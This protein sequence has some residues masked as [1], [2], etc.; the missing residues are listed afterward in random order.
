MM[1]SSAQLATARTALFSPALRPDR[2]LKAQGSGA[3]C[4]VVDLEDAV[5][6]ADKDAA[7]EHLIALL[8]GTHEAGA[9]AGPVA[10]R[11]NG[12]QTEA[13]RADLEALR[14][15]ARAH[16]H[17]ASARAAA[18]AVGGSAPGCT[19]APELLDAVL[20]P[21]LESPDQ[22]RDVRDG[23]GFEVGIVGTVESAAGLLALE[24][25]VAEPGVVR[26]AVGALDLAFDLGCGADSRTMAAAMAR[27]VTVSRARGLAGPLDS[28]TPEFRDLEPVRR[29]ALRAREDGFTGKLCI[30][31]AQVEAAAEAFAPTEEEIAWARSVVEAVD[32]ASAV[33]GAMVDAPVIARAR[34][35][36]G[37]G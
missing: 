32:G 13:G 22:V 8:A 28:P 23:L 6:A 16:E 10:V 15:A 20:I 3:D 19:E 11:L 36:L 14:R 4:V 9:L 35:L 34:R 17:S 27:V 2:V 31:P 21:K 30:H 18:A 5:A 25:I 1:T 12:P 26:L 7:R 29:A 37:E 33:D 24:E